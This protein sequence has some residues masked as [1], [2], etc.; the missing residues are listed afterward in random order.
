[1]VVL[2]FLKIHCQYGSNVHWD[3]DFGCYFQLH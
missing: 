2:E 3:V 1:M